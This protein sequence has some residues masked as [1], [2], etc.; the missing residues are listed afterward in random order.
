MS[1]EGG[2]EDVAWGFIGFSIF[3]KTAVAL[4]MTRVVQGLA[5]HALDRRGKSRLVPGILDLIS[6]WLAGG[7]GSRNG[8]FGGGGG[9]LRSTLSNLQKISFL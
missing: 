5:G 6:L 7:F 1:L 4:P 3:G 9:G 2:A 8:G